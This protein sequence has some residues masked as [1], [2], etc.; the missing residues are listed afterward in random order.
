MLQSGTPHWVS[1]G[2]ESRGDCG[3]AVLDLHGDPAPKTD[4]LDG[5]TQK[6]EGANC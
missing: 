3:T 1:S 5:F 6:G 2:G 4:G